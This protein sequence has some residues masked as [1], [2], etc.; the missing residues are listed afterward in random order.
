MWY[1]VLWVSGFKTENDTNLAIDHGLAMARKLKK[2][3]T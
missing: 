2:L 3:K 1:L